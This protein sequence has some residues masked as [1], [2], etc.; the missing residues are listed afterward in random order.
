MHFVEEAAFYAKK[1]GNFIIKP[2][3][4]LLCCFAI[5]V[6]KNDTTVAQKV[7]NSIQT[8][9]SQTMMDIANIT[10]SIYYKVNYFL[11]KQSCIT[12]PIKK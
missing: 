6:A 10:T 1:D 11:Q 2:G 8:S 9:G 5:F 12:N 3:S 4:D 7:Y